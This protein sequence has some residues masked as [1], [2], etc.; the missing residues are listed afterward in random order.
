MTKNYSR[1]ALYALGETLGESVTKARPY[2]GV[3]CGSGGSNKSTSTSQVSYP[4][5]LK[6]LLARY[7]QEGIRLADTPY[8]DYAG[9]RYA[10]LNS[11]QTAALD[12]MVDRATNGSEVWN[13]AEDNLTQMMGGQRNPYLDQMVSDAQRS[14]VDSYNLTTKPQMESAMVG[15]GSFGNSGLQQMQQKSVSD[16]QQNLGQVATQMYGGAYDADQNRRLQALGMAQQYANQDYTDL[17]QALIAGDAYQDQ[18]QNNLDFAYEQYQ[19]R[20]DDPYKKLQ[21]MSG[22]LS[23]GQGSTTTTKGSGGK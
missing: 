22:T 20:Q 7:A 5:E 13:T 15:S 12:N 14:V 21:A 2:G 6:P 1:A 19:N 4:D 9:Q 8:Q 11:T 23:T 10:D 16:L 18:D 3:W 17:N